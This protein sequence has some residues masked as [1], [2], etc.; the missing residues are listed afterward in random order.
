MTL[1]RILVGA[2]ALLVAL[3]TTACGSDDAPSGPLPDASTLIRDAAAATRDI[4]STHFTIEVTGTIPG[5]AVRSLD[6][7]LTRS[8]E[9]QGTG[10]IEQVGQ[11]VEVS[12]VLVDDTLHLKG[13]TGGY[14]E[15]PAALSSSIYD[16]SAVLD[17]E[18]GV[19][20]LLTSLREPRTEG[21][22]ELDGVS[23]YKVS[24]SL[25]KDVLSGVVPGAD[26]DADVTFWL[27]ADDEHLP[28]KASAT[29]S[30]EAS[31]DITLSE[32]NA[33][34]TVEPPA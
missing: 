28:V 27:S 26:G 4:E 19:A 29:L 11:L 12:F 15:I 23:T 8:G 30:D 20:K 24:G 6:G 13:P 16:P 33:P 5:L 17:P 25:A 22:D 7:D 1:R 32:V 10:T 18:R 31:V 34:V 2:C 21:T 3:T 9:A 14:Q